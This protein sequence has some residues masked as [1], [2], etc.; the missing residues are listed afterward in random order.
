MK[1]TT[2]LRSELQRRYASPDWPVKRREC[3]DKHDWNCGVCF[4]DWRGVCPL[5]CHHLHYRSLWHEDPE[6]DIVPLCK[7]HHPKGKL[8]AYQIKL[9]RRSYRWQR[10]MERLAAWLLRASSRTIRGLWRRAVRRGR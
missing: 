9:W 2:V 1:S 8:T 3:F 7:R 6:L 10:G 4:H 5:Q